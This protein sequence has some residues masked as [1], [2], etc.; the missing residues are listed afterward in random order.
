MM[1]RP[2]SEN[3]EYNANISQIPIFRSYNEKSDIDSFREKYPLFYNSFI[4]K[5]EED[6]NEYIDSFKCLEGKYDCG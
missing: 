3:L 6:L 4:K 1:I 2:S 5:Q